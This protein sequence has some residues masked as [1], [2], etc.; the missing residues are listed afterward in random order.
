MNEWLDKHTWVE[1]Y[2]G[3]PSSSMSYEKVR[4]IKSQ[5]LGRWAGYTKDSI[6]WHD[7]EGTNKL[8]TY[9]T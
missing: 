7:P 2:N 1:W 6:G 9:L 3:T 5:F 4:K 8:E